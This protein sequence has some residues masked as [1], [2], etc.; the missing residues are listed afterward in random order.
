MTG[1]LSWR[2]IV[3]AIY[4][5][6]VVFIG[7][8][9]R[10]LNEPDEGRYAAI[11]REMAE[12]GD[13]LVPHLNGIPHFQKPPI[14]YWSTALAFQCF[15][16]NEASA[17][18]P[19]T[20]AALGML[21]LTFTIG[22]RLYG[23]ETA[24]GAVFVLVAAIEFFGLARMLTPDMMMSFWI[25]AAVFCLVKH[26]LDG[27]RKW[28]WLFFAA[29]GLGFLTKG[30]MAF[31]VPVSAAVAWRVAAGPAPEGRRLPWLTGM[32]LALAIGLSW[33]VVLA[34]REP[35]LGSYFAGYELMQRFTSKVHGRSKPV[36]FFVPVLLAGL[37][38]WTPALITMAGQLVRRWR[39]G[40]RPTPDAWL[41]VGWV[42][43]PLIVLSLSGSKLLTYV[44]PLFP[45]LAIALAQ[46]QCQSPAIARRGHGVAAGIFLL[47]AVGMLLAHR[48]VPQPDLGGF[49]VPLLFVALGLGAAAGLRKLAANP[50]AALGCISLAASV[51]WLWTV[52][53]ADRV[54]DLLG[55]QSSIRPLAR[56]VLR[57]ADFD[58]ATFFVVDARLH[59]WEFYLRRPV[60]VT[61]A[62]SDVVLPLTP[63]QQERLLP[64]AK[65][66][67]EIAKILERRA[68]A[69]GLIRARSYAK[70]FSTNHWVVL[71]QASHYY[72][73]ATRDAALARPML[74]E[75][76]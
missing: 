12:N 35:Q 68:P 62:D 2:G 34:I 33:F 16:V 39:G 51:G 55:A 54:N 28:G 18:L 58:R 67:A 74:A 24:T 6:A 47:A 38:P 71:G 20:L 29:M 11:A 57:A 13:W 37:L 15:G 41:L 61:L 9:D 31:V 65:Q 27:G 59:G 1:G 32:A 43:P 19:S 5:L 49:A 36:W 50:V 30:P 23:V 26:R 42:V 7:L 75:K 44:L 52:N 72:L 53:Q 4:V 48:W 73:I 14:I 10:G 3:V 45:P 22:R 64:D 76:P 25:A 40:W 63:E 66:S 8:G 46:W 60:S 70:E 69:Y 21:A 17:R 56:Q